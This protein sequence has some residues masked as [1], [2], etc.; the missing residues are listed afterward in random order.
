MCMA[1]SRGKGLCLQ[2]GII[3]DPFCD[4]SVLHL[5]C[6]RG[7]TCTVVSKML[8]P[9]KLGEGTRSSCDVSYNWMRTYN[10]LKNA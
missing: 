4:E 8:S 1:G 2:K 10:Y 6:I 7:N 5:D 3:R 9:G